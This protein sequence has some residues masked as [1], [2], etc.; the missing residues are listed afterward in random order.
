MAANLTMAAA[1]PSHL[2]EPEK[3]DRL[4]LIRTENV[5]PVTFRRLLERFGSAGDALAALPELA[6][7]GGRRGAFGVFSKAA[8]ERELAAYVALGARVV[9]WGEPVY[10]ASLAAIE[11]A[12]PVLALRGHDHLLDRRMVAVVGARN[13]SANGRRFAHRLGAELAAAGL[14][15]VSGLARGIDGAAHQGA[16]EG[17]T[18]AVLAGG[19]DVVFPTEHQALYDA[20][21]ERGAVIAEHPPGTVPRARHFPHRNSIISGL[22]LGTVVVEAAPRSGSLVTARLAGEQGREVFA[23]PGSPLDPRARGTNHLIR[24]GAVLVES[25]A[26]VLEVL[27]SL[28][29]RPFAETE[30][31]PWDGPTPTQPGEAVL[32]QARDRIM[33]ALGPAPVPVDE[34]V[35]LCDSTAPVLA[36]VLLEFELAGR[37]ER[38]PGNQVA[39]VVDT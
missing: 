7:R 10:P 22:A 9:M 17:G 39:L 27:D 33:A 14:V 16:L 23:V 11:D 6:C 38:H 2:S 28:H 18:V 13:A 1:S 19:V 35:R 21:V 3:I 20:I 5:G 34:L 24:Q 4:R 32:D 29:S 12:P 25:A 36:T 15:V 26:D 30:P 31:P 8:A 37:L